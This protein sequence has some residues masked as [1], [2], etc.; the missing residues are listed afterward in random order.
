MVKGTDEKSQATRTF[1]SIHLLPTHV[2][3]RPFKHLFALHDVFRLIV[4]EQVTQLARLG[5]Y[6]AQRFK[7]RRLELKDL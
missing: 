4:L 7:V 6:L 3:Q 5:M 2:L 1:P